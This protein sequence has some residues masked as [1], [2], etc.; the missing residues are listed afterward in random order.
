M[1]GVFVVKYGYHKEVK[2]KRLLIAMV[3]SCA[4]IALSAPAALAR[5]VSLDSIDGTAATV[6]VG[7][8]EANETLR[9]AYG[10]VDGGTDMSA[11][12]TFSA[13]LFPSLILGIS[14]LL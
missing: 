5:T 3:V 12:G 9:L 7:P 6:T 8:G 11:W 14:F 1:G 10:K 2:M 4:A 13:Y